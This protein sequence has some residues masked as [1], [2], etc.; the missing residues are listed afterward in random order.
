MVLRFKDTRD[1]TMLSRSKAIHTNMPEPP[2]DRKLKAR[3]VHQTVHKTRAFRTQEERDIDQPI[4][5][6]KNQQKQKSR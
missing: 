1:V 2:S 4:S 6:I 5:G 3:K